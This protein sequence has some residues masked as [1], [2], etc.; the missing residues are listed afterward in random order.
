MMTKTCPYCGRSFETERDTKKWCSQQCWK[1]H[2]RGMKYAAPIW[3]K[4]C[5]CG[6]MAQRRKRK[7]Q[8]KTCGKPECVKQHKRRVS[9]AYNAKATASGVRKSWP[10]YAA[11]LR[12]RNWTHELIVAMAQETRHLRQWLKATETIQCEICGATVQ[13]S[14]GVPRKF[15]SSR[16]RERAKARRR[17]MFHFVMKALSG[18]S[19]RMRYGF[20]GPKTQA[21]SSLPYSE[22]Q[23]VEHIE[24]TWLPDMSWHNWGANG[25]HI[26][27]IIPSTCFDLSTQKGINACFALSNLRALWA[28]T[29]IARAH[30]HNGI[31]NINKKNSL[32]FA[33]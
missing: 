31:G 19:R 24:S 33:T 22:Q 26:D 7:G 9:Q 8:P 21:I 4:C 27:H 32:C 28:T 17:P 20:A 13:R 15:C 11:S 2:A 30:G 5:V 12:G 23:F 10:S 29:E 14:G 16:C 18:C 3:V 1:S 25:W 6:E